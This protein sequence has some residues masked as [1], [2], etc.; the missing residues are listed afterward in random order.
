MRISCFWQNLLLVRVLTWNCFEYSSVIVSFV[1]WREYFSINGESYVWNGRLQWYFGKKCFLG[2]EFHESAPGQTWLHRY[3]FPKSVCHSSALYRSW[4]R[5]LCLKVS[6]RKYTTGL[7]CSICWAY[8]NHFPYRSIRNRYPIRCCLHSW[9]SVPILWWVVLFAAYHNHIL[10]VRL[11]KSQPISYCCLLLY[12]V[13]NCL[14]LRSL[15]FHDFYPA[16]INRVR[17]WAII[18][19]Q[20]VRQMSWLVGLGIPGNNFLLSDS[21]IDFGCRQSTHLLL[22]P[23]NS[24]R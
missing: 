22:H 2:D 6:R 14:Q 5:K 17:L 19:P 24:Q 23:Q 12:L 3:W 20:R 18:F 11:Y 21:R 7:H 9:M 8:I 10:S 15:S 13:P 1:D 16:K 4:R